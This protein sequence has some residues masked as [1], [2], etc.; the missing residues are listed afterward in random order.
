[1]IFPSLAPTRNGSDIQPCLFQDEMRSVPHSPRKTCRINV[2]DLQ[3]L[4][5]FTLYALC[6][7]HD[8]LLPGWLAYKARISTSLVRCLQGRLTPCA[9]RL[10]EQV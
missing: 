10:S 8:L 9:P 1:M 5:D 2:G 6:E 3:P 4:S 7:A